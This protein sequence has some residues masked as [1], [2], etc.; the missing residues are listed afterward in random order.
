VSVAPSPARP[1]AVQAPTPPS[2]EAFEAAVLRRN[3]EQALTEC[4]RIL[5][6]VDDRYG[7]IDGVRAGV[8]SSDPH[9]LT[10]FATRFA[11][12]FGQLICDP[13]TLLTP[14]AF[15]RLSAAHRW[16]ELLFRASGFG[17]TEHL[18]PLIS[19]AEGQGRR[20]PTANLP[21]LLLI[22]SA[23]SG[24]EISLDECL[25]AA[26]PGAVVAFLNYL[27]TRFCFTDTGHDFR[28]RLLEWL[29]SKLHMVKLGGV[30]LQSMASPYMHASYALSA[31]KH[32]IKAE[33]IAQMRR[34]ALE[35]GCQEWGLTAPSER[36]KDRS[37][38]RTLVVTTENF[39]HGHSV[40][41]THSIAIE[42]LKKRF[43]LIGTAQRE[44]LSAPVEALFDEV[45]TYP[46][47]LPFLEAVRRMADEIRAREPAMVLHLGVGMSPMVIALAS[48]RLAPVQAA[49]FGHTAT[50]KSP[51]IDYMILPADFVGDPACFSETLACVPAKAMP[52]RKREDVDY[53]DIRQ[54]SAAARASANYAVRIA[55]PAS[56]MKLGPPVFDALAR[57]AADAASPVEFHFFPLACAGLGHDELKRGLTGRLPMAIVN[58]E[59]PY[60]DYVE[61]LAACDFFVSP[62]PYGNMN[63]I[64]DAVLVGL[65]GVCLDGPE[66]HAHADA[67]YFARLGFPPELTA[68]TVD[69]YVAAIARLVRE[70]DWLARCRQIAAQA[71]LGAAFFDGDARLFAD[72]VE[73]L[74][75]RGPAATGRA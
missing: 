34:A 75:A 61:R 71:D 22:Y 58:E 65:P 63:S 43:R 39:S 64:V 56:A 27:G 72:A 10:R 4:L 52:Y 8:P 42:A 3:W 2:L 6:S 26:G 53:R 70:P 46:Q 13:Q 15:E 45:L 44:Q 19:T 18:T 12:A 9:L 30:T 40:W 16:I 23:A 25:A 31:R 59:L 35:A 1:G 51:V 28:E 55:I 48:L 50:T 73:D 62:F 14:L 57:S 67:A 7:R 47:Q 17:S 38:R 29:P 36:S 60:A 54:R 66:A 74:V 68:Q 24:M 21:R 49:S 5:Q 41:R 20:V 33:V 11:A 37:R 69:A 32:E